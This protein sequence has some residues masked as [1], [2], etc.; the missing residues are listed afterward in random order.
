LPVAEK[1]LHF[2]LMEEAWK[3]PY[4]HRKRIDDYSEL[5]DS[6]NGCYPNDDNWETDIILN[7]K[8][9]A[10]DDGRICDIEYYKVRDL[11]CGHG[12]PVTRDLELSAADKNVF[13][14]ILD[15]NTISR[16]ESVIET[17]LNKAKESGL[18]YGWTLKKWT[19]TAASFISPEGKSVSVTLK[20]ILKAIEISYSYI[21][22][23]SSRDFWDANPKTLKAE[24][25]DALLALFSLID[26][27]DYYRR[28]ELLAEAEERAYLVKKD[29]C[30]R[31]LCDACEANDTK[32]ARQYISYAKE[33]LPYNSGLI[34]PLYTAIKH[35]NMPLVRDL[36][37]NGASVNEQF[38]VG[39]AIVTTLS[40]AIETGNDAALKLCLSADFSG[41]AHEP[42]I[43]VAQRLNRPDVIIMLLKKGASFTA[44]EETL[45]L[46][47]DAMVS[48]AKYPGIKWLPEHLEEVYKTGDKKSVKQ[49]LKSIDTTGEPD[50]YGTYRKAPVTYQQ[51]AVEWI[52][53]IKDIEL[54]R[55]CASL[56]YVIQS[57]YFKGIEILIDLPA[58]WAQYFK[59]VFAHER[60]YNR[61]V[62]NALYAAIKNRNVSACKKLLKYFGAEVDLKC[63]HFA[64]SNRLGN[65][66]WGNVDEN[67]LKF[68]I[69]HFSFP[70]KFNVE[71]RNHH[72]WDWDGHFNWIFEGVIGRC[73]QKLCL[74]LF[75]KIPEIFESIDL[76][77]TL[78]FYCYRR[79]KNDDVR[80]IAEES[81][82]PVLYKKMDGWVAG[83]CTFIKQDI[84]R[85]VE[86]LLEA[87]AADNDRF[88]RFLQC[89]EIYE[90]DIKNWISLIDGLT[91]G[92]R[93]REDPYHK[94]PEQRIFTNGQ[95]IKSLHHIYEVAA[96]IANNKD[97]RSLLNYDAR[98]FIEVM[99]GAKI[100]ELWNVLG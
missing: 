28:E 91:R 59:S 20:R 82:V 76:A 30:Y 74:H 12:R 94:N 54:L 68:V 43:K 19:S 38:H 29:L 3:V 50:K 62:Q 23:L 31:F 61:V 8:A 49:M 2:L 99:D 14:R 92:F 15:E 37:K 80:T 87:N 22:I 56:N 98:C 45:H 67:T 63:V 79:D 42:S 97:D 24:D 51:M 44:N 90:A 46:G 57:E 5:I 32:A 4:L 70:E 53:S 16:A 36:I 13:A 88:A 52:V 86:I 66:I 85:I 69:D 1:D 58:S 96:R 7:L 11:T 47:A 65:D 81:L 93:N 75:E 71:C 17:L 21:D 48:F 34:P 10:D 9:S 40:A 35:N 33:K 100:P 6:V 25:R 55:Y 84:E 60:Y 83:E 27:S 78:M 89:F 73:S 95:V 39:D 77:S 72:D 64:G 18:P 26:T 41:E